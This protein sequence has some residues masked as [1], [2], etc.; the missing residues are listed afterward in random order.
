MRSRLTS[1]VLA[2]L[3]AVGLVAGLPGLAHAD[4]AEPAGPAAAEEM[5][6][7]PKA[8]PKPEPKAEPEPESKPEP[9]K[10]AEPAPAPE[11]SAEPEESAPADE[12]RPEAAEPAPQ[13]ETSPS[14]PA[15]TADDKPA[16]PLVPDPEDALAA[17]DSDQPQPRPRSA[18]R[19]GFV[20]GDATTHTL[21]D[22]AT[23]TYN[24]T[25]TAG[26]PIRVSG[27]GWLAKPDRVDEG[28]EGS[29]VGF[30][31]IDGALGQLERRRLLENPRL[32]ETI[33]NATVWGVV[34]AD[35][36]GSFE[37]ELDWPDAGKA[38]TDPAWQ[39]GD[40]FTLQAL[41]GT[42]YS[43][44]PSV[45]P[46]LR[47][48]VSRTAGLTLT[49][50]G[51]DPDT[52]PVDPEPEPEP[53]PGR[54]VVV[55]QPQS[56]LVEAGEPAAFTASATG[57][58]EPQVHW[59]R[60]TDAGATW[61][62]LRGATGASY[63]IEKARTAQN[64]WLYRAVFSNSAAPDGVASDPATLS[65]T[66]RGNV[67]STCG[68]SYG[69]GTA[70]T[71]VEFCFRGPEKVV[72]GQPIVLEGVSGYLATDGQTGS[73]INFFLDAEFSGDPNTVYSKQLFTN[74]ATGA[75][76]S[77]RRTNAI[78]QADA[79]GAWRVEIPWPTVD[80]V[81][82]TS[83]G[84]GSYTPDEL[85]AKFAPG[86]THSVRM[87]TGS[88]LNNPADRQ[89]GASVYFTVV[90]SLD[91]EVG[92][93]EPLYE[94]QT[95]ESETAGDQAVAWVQQQVGS[96][97]SIALTGAGWLA[98]DRQWGSTVVVRLQ[99]ET[100]AYYQPSDAD[101]AD[102]TV[103]QVIQVPESGELDA[104]LALPSGA[105]G[106]DYVAVELTTSD[107]ETP[108]GDV[109]RHWVS[110]PV[111]IDNLAYVPDLG[112]DATCTAA[113]GAASY[114]L[115]PGMKTPAANVGGTIRLVGKDWCNLVGG[116]S[117]I[118]IKIDDGAY[119]R[120]AGQTAPLYDAN[121]GAE[122]GECPAGICVSN[123][124]IWYV[125]EADEQGSFDVNIPLPTRTN[126]APGFGEGAYTLRIMTR[127]L[128]A[129]PYYQG[130]RPD[131][132]R[133]M[134][135]PGFTVVAEGESL[136][137]VKPGRPSA[138]PDPL[139]AADDLTDVARGTVTVDQQAK[140]WLVTVPAAAH[141]DWVYVN[142]YD[143]ASPRFPWASQ[144]FEV[145]ANHKVSLPVTGMTLPSGTNKVSVQDR[146]GGLL[147]WTTVTVAAASSTRPKLL[148]T[149]VSFNATVG[150]PKPEEAPAQPVAGYADLTEA[151]AG[152]ATATASDGKLT[153]T[154]PGVAGG[155]W[156]YLTLYTETGRVA[157]VDW[158]QVGSDHTFT[159]AV[160]KLPN[161]S[162]KLALQGSDGKL[163]GWVPADGPGPLPVSEPGAVPGTQQPSSQPDEPAGSPAGAPQQAET[164][165]AA[166]DGNLTL[167]LVGLAFLV[168]AGSAAGVI[169]LS[170]PVR[171]AA[172]SKG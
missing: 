148:V 58:P 34:W 81:S 15:D 78:V 119:S 131:P 5:P 92:V 149:P 9:E 126:S 60:S 21:P 50:A 67:R 93:T 66:P 108:L 147:G 14:E 172:T 123:K 127:T 37:L 63:A 134:K 98:K 56:Q 36:S 54:P 33:A 27:A 103:W 51:D 41:S 76:I 150:K 159:V 17:A 100:G 122:T 141:G 72:A 85:A 40:S 43:N 12:P 140:R 138:A 168:L 154:V 52:P 116:G 4:A 42:L 109:A 59:Q 91:D 45:D 53:D 163:L 2:W 151:N 26:Q 11:S 20:T 84:Q 125:I 57:D 99:D 117:L 170:S 19:S 31:L 24:A 144:W 48:D 18:A 110:E 114:E 7:E 96:G 152:K 115:A 87:L 77:D 136:D 128:S 38:V 65:V 68:A 97:Q 49:V 95:F 71:G 6:A 145:D 16:D 30:K 167:I 111:T 104:E 169:A 118:A 143:G 70:H 61:Q 102:P 157:G 47:P 46:G 82:P 139:H 64:G 124:T 135:S 161:G 39:P 137:D 165:V 29:V 22:G 69:P 32:G 171:P 75:T 80:T 89:R 101:P 73:V 90:G 94:H 106:G 107:D 112:E 105:K 13:P 146:D 158:V 164:P 142:L 121:L 120:L 130:Q 8:E 162:H 79:A 160:G 166:G 1:L 3:L 132:S 129:D 155:E 62:D 35:S 83:N 133:T 88:L 55:E 153:V 23:L 10:S 25:V 86:T 156:V 28:E 44:Q 113:P 74:P